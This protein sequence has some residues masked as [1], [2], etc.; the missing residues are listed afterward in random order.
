M[1]PGGLCRVWLRPDQV[2]PVLTL[3]SGQDS[4]SHV[5]WPKLP[6]STQPAM[7]GDRCTLSQLGMC[8]NILGSPLSLLIPPPGPGPEQGALRPHP[9]QDRCSGRWLQRFLV[10]ATLSCARMCPFLS[11][12]FGPSFASLCSPGPA[13]SSLASSFHVTWWAYVD[14]SQIGPL[15]WDTAC[16]TDACGPDLHRPHTAEGTGHAWGS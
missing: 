15:G 8:S 16:A 1:A 3:S 11:C 6:I 12:S 13:P 5:V 7:L 4:C 2:R 14:P 10:R 9:L